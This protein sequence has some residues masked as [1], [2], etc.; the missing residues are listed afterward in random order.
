MTLFYQIRTVFTI[1]FRHLWA[2]R[3]MTA[4]TTIGLTVAVAIIMVVP[5]YADAVSFRVLE[6]KLSEDSND[7]ARPPFAYM[8]N[9]IGA[10]KGP[11]PW[12]DVAEADDYLMEDGSRPLGLPQE[13]AI[14]HFETELFQIFA[15]DSPNYDDDDLALARLNLATTSNMLDYITLTEGQFPNIVTDSNAPIE[16]MVTEALADQFGWQVGE[17]YI[18][19]NNLTD[20]QYTFPITIA[21]IW[22]ANNSNEPY[23]YY[24]PNVFDDLL[25]MPESTFETRIGAEMENAVNLA[26]WYW[27]MDGRLVGTDDVP[28]LVNGIG[29]IERDLQN[30]LPNATT[31]LAPTDALNSYQQ[32]VNRLSTLLFAFNVPTIGL[33]LAFVSLVGSL[34]VNERRN[35]FAVLRSRGGTAVQ[36]IAIALLEV[37]LLSLIAFVL[38][39]LLGLALTQ[40]ISSARSFMDFSGGASLRVAL[41]EDGLQ[42]GIIAAVVAGLA[43]LLP[44]IS[45]SRDTIISYKLAQARSLRSPWWQRAWLDMLLLAVTAYGLYTLNEQGSLIVQSETGDPFQ[46][47]LLL[48][49]PA[50]TI[51]SFSLLFLRILP[52]FMRMVAWVLQQ[53][54]GVTVLQAVRYLA[55]TPHHYNTPLILLVLTVSFSVFIASLARTLDFYLYDQSYYTAGADMNLITPTQT[56][57]NSNNGGGAGLAVEEETVFV[58]LPISEYE[59]IDGVRAAARVGGYRGRATIGSNK[60]PI[61]FMGIDPFDFAE[62]AYWRTD[63]SRARLGTLMNALSSRQE[64]V[65]VSN[66]FLA[67]NGLRGGDTMRL[68]VVLEGI[69]VEVETQIVGVF[70]YFPTWFPEDSEP[71]VVGN[72]NYI[73]EQAGSEFPY[74]V[75]LETNGV[76]DERPLTRALN[77]KQLFGTSWREPHGGITA[78]FLQPE[79]QGLF[80]LL[81]VG[82]IAAAV[83]TIMGLLLYT[84]FSYRRRVV[85]LGVLRAMGLSARKM[86]ALVGWELMLLILSGIVL[87][88]SLGVS[89]SRLFIP[90]LQIGTVGTTLTPPFLVEIAWDA[91][92]QV[93]FLFAILFIVA[94]ASLVMLAMQMKIF[95]AIK[96]G[97]TV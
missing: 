74:R 33:V 22:Q 58:F 69:E 75:W 10:W 66:S 72:L 65:L 57:S 39:T 53:R 50:I 96:L 56:F 81:S 59:T 40:S 14:H 28:R 6:Q 82:F 62:A 95:M 35:E 32:S 45:S 86:T 71:L 24:A 16:V 84:V 8:F 42:A 21:G 25:I 9:Y 30:I 15:P 54:N 19:F 31:F 49:L 37:V 46:N 23:W 29:R 47:P 80:G 38:G 88:T 79:R 4:V 36:V 1:T 97:E 43:Q 44:V 52:L 3:W 18:A 78:V 55:R 5:L 51:F 89:V 20:Q 87:G 11:L 83:L 94:L 67:Q 70:D 68:G 93:Y 48:W 60:V 34:T 73:F 76:L 90:Y 63:F 85:E 92:T 17:Q 26:T 12:A 7:G 27:V 61:D 91:V 13:L 64:G 2:Q 77:S 41:T